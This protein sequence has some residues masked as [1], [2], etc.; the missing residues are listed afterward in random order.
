MVHRRC[1]VADVILVRTDRDIL[2]TQPGIAAAKH[3]D[4]VPRRVGGARDGGEPE[5]AV[6]RGPRRAECPSGQRAAQQSLR[7]RLGDVDDERTL[8][9]IAAGSRR[10]HHFRRIERDP[11]HL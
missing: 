2:P 8:R 10:E 6:H 4:D 3:R 11:L 1:V 7:R 9:R 5:T